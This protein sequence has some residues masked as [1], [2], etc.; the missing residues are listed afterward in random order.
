MSKVL[1]I[2]PRY[3]SPAFQAITQ[4][5]GLMYIGAC[6]K[7]AGHEPRIHDCAIDYKNLH[8]L[9]QIIQDWKPDFIG[10]S[11]VVMELEQTKFIMK[12]VREFL[13]NIPVTFG[14]PWPTANPEMAMKDYGA[15]FV[16]LGEGEKVFPELI[17]AVNKNNP[18]DSI[19]GTALLVDGKIK[20][21]PRFYLSEDE[22]NALPFPAWELLNH[23]LYAKTISHAAV[24]TRPYMTIVTSRGCPYN[25]AYCHQTM[26]KVY[27]KRSAKSVVAEI[28]GLKTRFGFNEFEIADD[29][30]NLDRKRMREILNGIMNEVRNI[31]LH[32]P[33]GLRADLLEKEDIQLLKKAGTVS[34]FFAVETSS[35][36]LQKMIGKNLNLEKVTQAISCSVAAG[37]YTSGYFMIGFPTE[38]YQESW[39]TVKYACRSALHR[40]LF[41]TTMPYE[42]TALAD[43]V[44]ETIK[45]K[46]KSIYSNN[47]NYFNSRINISAMSDGELKT[48]FRCAYIRF[49]MSLRRIV[50]IFVVHPQKRSFPR[51][52]FLILVKVLPKIIRSG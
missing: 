27:R 22:L 2:K 3:L 33:N 29:C 6:L 45:N 10:I 9:R 20:I 14:G 28:K 4:P 31:K 19:S 24:G 47:M 18:T 43:M 25:C 13:G 40:A 23:K 8:I 38:T 30:F 44:P 7:N 51:Y 34:A 21:N 26:G 37:I 5:L 49:Y 50:N 36:R 35:P 1:L 11:I 16:V 12:L 42:G 32:F 48:V 52:M 39:A 46:Q 41:F 17:D 15:D